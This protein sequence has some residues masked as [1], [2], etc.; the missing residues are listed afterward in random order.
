ESERAGLL[1][2]KI[3]RS[4][5]FAQLLL[6]RG[7]DT[8]AKYLRWNLN[9]ASALYSPSSLPDADI[10]AELLE[11]AIANGQLIFVCGDYDADGICAT[12]LFVRGLRALNALAEY[13]LPVRGRDGYGLNRNE[14]DLAADLGASLLV[15][16][17]CGS[18]NGDVVAYAHA[19]G[20]KVIVTDHH[21]VSGDGPGADAFVNPQRSDSNYPEAGL[22]GAAVAWKVLA[23]LYLRLGKAAP[24]DLLDYAS[25]ATITDMMQLTG[26]NRLLCRLGLAEIEAWRRPCFRAL[27]DISGV[28]GRPLNSKSVSFFMGPRIN[29]VGR[30]NDPRYC[31]ELLLCDDPI[32]CQQLAQFVEECNLLRRRLQ[33]EMAD[34]ICARLNIAEARQKGFIFEAGDFHTGVVGIAAGMLASDYNLPCLIGRLDGNYITGSGRSAAGL[35][36]HAALSDCADCLV[37][38]GGHASAAGFCLC[39]DNLPAFLDRFGAALEKHRF[40][41][42]PLPVDYELKLNELTLGF[43]KELRDLE[44]T[45]QGMP[46][47]C[48]LFKGVSFTDI[49]SIKDGKY[50]TGSLRQSG[51]SGKVKM[52]AFASADDIKRFELLSR[53][54]DVVAS[55]EVDS[56][57]GTDKVCVNI[58]YMV[59]ADAEQLRMLDAAE[60]IVS[61]SCGQVIS[62]PKPEA[63]TLGASKTACDGSAGEIA[64]KSTVKHTVVDKRGTD[65]IAYVREVIEANASRPSALQQRGADRLGVIVAFDS[66]LKQFPADLKAQVALLTWKQ[67]FGLEKHRSFSD[68]LLLD[69]PLDLE[70]MRSKGILDGT[71]RLHLLFAPEGWNAVAKHMSLWRLTATDMDHAWARLSR[72][73]SNHGGTYVFNTQDAQLRLLCDLPGNRQVSLAIAIMA[74][75]GLIAV[76]KAELTNR[77]TLEA[78][79]AAGREISWGCSLTFSRMGKWLASFKDTRRSLENCKTA[80]ISLFWRTV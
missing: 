70:Q 9:S 27:G 37:N 45:G 60:G 68:V 7:I 8:P 22:C 26:E 69:P 34:T 66:G 30:V 39:R 3:K 76:E 59:A 42:P 40:P 65:A 46:S 41:V 17:D 1:A 16:V 67:W 23:A 10:A 38:F 50:L 55:L 53:V 64:A 72:W 79:G 2:S 63:G 54:C 29:A 57:G 13:A 58:D 15:T 24:L 31:A 56:F 74:E 5:R 19:K 49:R 71:E 32:R 18:S 25:F 21:K 51:V 62:E 36:L 43:A 77:L 47:P 80:D 33:S 12:A 6:N 78:D 44:P 14:I 52:T 28:R 4:P 48:F 35:D 61:D 75:L 73:L 11:A 20:L